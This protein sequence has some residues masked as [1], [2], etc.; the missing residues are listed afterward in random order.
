MRAMLV[1]DEQADAVRAEPLLAQVLQQ[2]EAAFHAAH[3][4]SQIRQPE[5][6]LQKTLARVPRRVALS[7]G[8]P[9]V[10]SQAGQQIGKIHPQK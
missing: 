3:P 5:E 7:G 10:H 9:G 6:P 2:Q 4:S 1:P 8:Y